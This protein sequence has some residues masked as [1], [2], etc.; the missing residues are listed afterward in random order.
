M[1]LIVIFNWC[2]L[3]FA[4]TK[5]K[6]SNDGTKPLPEPMFPSQVFYAIHPQFHKKLTSLRHKCS[7]ITLMKLLPYHRH[8][9]GVNELKKKSNWYIKI[10]M[11]K[12]LQNHDYLYSYWLLSVCLSLYLWLRL[13]RQNVINLYQH[14]QP[15][16]HTDHN[17]HIPY[18][19]I[20]Q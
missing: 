17:N 12:H 6:K 13:C 20:K 14:N 3:I 19:L 18:K 1:V 10:D 16:N 5:Q 11:D 4:T 2:E 9:R 7:E 15:G 8:D